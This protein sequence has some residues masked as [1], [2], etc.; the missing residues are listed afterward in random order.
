MVYT[1]FISPLV[2]YKLKGDEVIDQ[3]LFSLMNDIIILTTREQNRVQGHLRQFILD[4][5]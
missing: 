3:K 4:D 5:K 1:H 2:D